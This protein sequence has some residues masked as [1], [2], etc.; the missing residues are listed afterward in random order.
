MTKTYNKYKSYIL[1][2]VMYAPLGFVC[3]LIGQYLSSIGFSGTQVGVVTSVGTLGAVLGGLFW[4][5]IFANAKNRRLVVSIMFLGAMF[6]GLISTRIF[7]FILYALIYGTMYFFMGPAHGLCDTIVIENGE[8]FAP[9]RAM[10][11]IGYA[12]A[13][14]FG[15]LYS[16]K[17]GLISIFFMFAIAY[18]VSSFIIMTEKEPEHHKEA[19]EKIKIAEL[20]SNR[21][22]VK[23][24]ICSFFI[25]GTT[26]ANNTYFSYL[27][28]EAGG[29]LAGIGLAFLLMAGSE[30]IFMALIPLF[31][32]KL[33]TEKLI[34]VGI[35][36]AV[37]RFA[38]Y[39]FG[40]STGVLLGTFFLQG[41]MDGILLVEIVR[42][43]E[44]I[45]EPRM[46]SISVSTYYSLGNYL[47][48]ILCN[49]VGGAILDIAGA[50]G[51]YLFMML[52]NVVGLVLYI[53]FGLHKTNR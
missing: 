2:L 41:I 37:L 28:K 22:Y 9:I 13:C 49:L 6:A 40:P 25:I 42:Y 8:N 24:L 44:K 35:L 17:H 5:K 18:F 4:G 15:G 1:Y 45:V 21:K 26:M 38:I 34:I 19:K 16:E 50:K 52:M 30:S 32:K 47:S 11:A 27:Y 31:N 53:S 3:P 29:D 48:S 46:T 51:V 43:F 14:Y 33:P 10:G 12:V 39:S 7:I 23:L 20:F 36:A